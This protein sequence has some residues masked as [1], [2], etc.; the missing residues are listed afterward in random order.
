MIHT[1]IKVSQTLAYLALEDITD[2][3]EDI[4]VVFNYRNQD[5]HSSQRKDGLMY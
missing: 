4:I 1:H 2:P 5:N 3:T